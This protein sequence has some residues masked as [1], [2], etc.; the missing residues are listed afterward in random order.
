MFGLGPASSA[1]HLLTDHHH[2]A[3]KG[4]ARLQLARHHLTGAEDNFISARCLCLFIVTTN[5][6]KSLNCVAVLVQKED[7]VIV[8][9]RHIHKDSTYGFYASCIA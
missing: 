3:L 2:P 9:L 1:H 4:A 8:V 7:I 5:T 6:Q